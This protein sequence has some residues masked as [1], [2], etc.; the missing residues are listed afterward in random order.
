MDITSRLRGKVVA[1][2]STNGHLLVI[3]TSCGAEL[4][5]AWLNGEGV[6]IKGKPAVA[7]SGVRLLARGIQDLQYFP[8]LRTK[9]QA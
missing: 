7:Q 5:V 8:A 3:R 9:G 2:V 1:E 4:T 6:P